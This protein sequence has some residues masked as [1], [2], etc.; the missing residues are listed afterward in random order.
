MFSIGTRGRNAA[1]TPEFIGAIP[2]DKVKDHPFDEK[3]IPSCF[4]CA[5]SRR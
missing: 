4:T 3:F 5:M 1:L 2:W